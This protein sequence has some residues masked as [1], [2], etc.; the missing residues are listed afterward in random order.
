MVIRDYLAIRR[1]SPSSGKICPQ[2]GCQV[3]GNSAGDRYPYWRPHKT[4]RSGLKPNQHGRGV[5]RKSVP[6]IWRK[7]STA[8]TRSSTMEHVPSRQGDLFH[9]AVNPIY[10]LFSSL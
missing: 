6:V 5:Y 2:V 4:S 8:S 7:L 1:R 9:C 3:G 10:Y